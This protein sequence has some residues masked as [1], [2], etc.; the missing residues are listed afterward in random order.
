[1]GSVCSLGETWLS[2]EYSCDL[3]QVTEPQLANISQV[4]QIE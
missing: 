3:R 1:M 2:F 4:R